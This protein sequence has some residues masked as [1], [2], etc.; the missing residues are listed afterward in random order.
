M[1]IVILL[2]A[3][4]AASGM[5]CGGGEGDGVSPDS[6]AGNGERDEENRSSSEE[7][8]DAYSGPSLSVQDLAAVPAS[9]GGWSWVGMLDAQA[10]AVG[11]PPRE[12]MAGFGVFDVGD[13]LDDASD[14]RGGE[15][16]VATFKEHYGIPID[17]IG[18]A[19]VLRGS[20][21][22]AFLLQGGFSERDIRS[23]LSEGRYWT[24]AGGSEDLYANNNQNGAAFFPD[25]GY[26]LL[27]DSSDVEELFAPLSAG[28]LS[29]QSPG[30][31]PEETG[32]TF[33]GSALENAV[34]IENLDRSWLE[35]V[36][37]I[38]GSFDFER[39]RSGLA[40]NGSEPV[41]NGLLEYWS[42]EVALS[43]V[44][45]SGVALSEF[46]D[47]VLLGEAEA[48]GAFLGTEIVEGGDFFA[49]W[50]ETLGISVAD[51]DVGM[52]LA[53]NGTA[54][55]MGGGY[56]PEAVRSALAASGEAEP[57]EGETAGYEAWELNSGTVAFVEDRIYVM[58]LDFEDAKEYYLDPLAQGEN[59]LKYPED[60]LLRAMDRAGRGWLVVGW[61][62]FYCE[63]LEVPA[64][65]CQAMALA[66]TTGD[67]STVEVN[68]VILFDSEDSAGDMIDEWSESSGPEAFPWISDVE[69]DGEFFV[70]EASVPTQAAVQFLAN[71]LSEGPAKVTRVFR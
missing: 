27:G 2:V 8:R 69:S 16:E 46:H 14:H 62:S 10:F 39:M 32:I 4:A 33:A 22:P 51:V 57:I 45:V 53:G 15:L 50:K 63:K 24:K 68:W 64:A 66:A 70:L 36:W 7:Q 43:G 55:V 71:L 61:H 34:V 65:G 47:Y 11:D 9:E 59:L 56:D 52:Q 31:W 41:Y 30:G 40:G 19:T 44:A 26:L 54:Y 23:A 3:L 13:I 21:E 35:R 58:D 67:R 1:V 5:A 6:R 38:R 29:P 12:I 49:G 28:P 48:I 17:D 25:D 42:S 18:T 37:A 20:E 60:P